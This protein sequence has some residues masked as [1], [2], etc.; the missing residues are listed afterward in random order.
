MSRLITEPNLSQHDEIYAHLI[1]LHEGRSEKESA[2]LN[3]RLIMLLINHIG[4]EEAVLEAIAL[5][6]K[7]PERRMEDPDERP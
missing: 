4:D 1:E 5:A 2:L 3:A 7:R 6:S